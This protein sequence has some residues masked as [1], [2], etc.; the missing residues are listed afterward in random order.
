MIPRPPR[1]FAPLVRRIGVPLV[2]LGILLPTGCAV[3]GEFVGFS[4]RANA[5][6]R[7]RVRARIDRLVEAYESGDPRAVRRGVSAGYGP[8]PPGS[9]VDALKARFRA[10]EE[11]RL[12]CT[13]DR[14]EVDA[15]GW[16]AHTHWQRRWRLRGNGRTITRY[17]ETTW[18]FVQRGDVL[19][20]NAHRGD[21]PFL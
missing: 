7:E 21:D 5:T 8:G 18:F 10:V 12:R 11:V 13:V 14:I 3:S 2:L 17:G 16:R 9:F 4:S 20:L 19:R 1:A 6:A 15:A